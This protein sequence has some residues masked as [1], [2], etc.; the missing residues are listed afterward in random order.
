MNNNVS[1]VKKSAVIIAVILLVAT[2]FCCLSSCQDKGPKVVL[3]FDNSDFSYVVYDTGDAYVASCNGAE[4]GTSVMKVTIP[5]TVTYE[6]KDYTI[7]GV[8]SLAFDHAMVSEIELSEGIKVIEPYAFAY[9]S[10]T[11]VTLPSTITT[12]G[13]YAFVN[14]MSLRR[15]N[16]KSAVPPTIGNNAFKYYDSTSAGYKVSGILKITVAKDSFDSYVNEWRDY[17]EV[18][19]K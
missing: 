15:L 6:D 5:D 12:I 11:I 13:E 9:C 1:I 10:A 19:T 4:T 16:V 7:V 18:I 14:N 8:S 3:Y 2:F 17:A